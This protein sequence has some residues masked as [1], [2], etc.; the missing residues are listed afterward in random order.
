MNDSTVNLASVSEAETSY[1][2]SPNSPHPSL[3]SDHMG[4]EIISI[5]D[6]S[7]LEN[8]IWELLGGRKLFFWVVRH[9]YINVD[10]RINHTE[11][12]MT[13]SI[14]LE[15]EVRANFQMRDLARDFIQVFLQMLHYEPSKV[16]VLEYL[17]LQS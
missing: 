10:R 16:E 2:S 12:L 17:N 15:D 9:P 6:D 8:N 14:L 1:R 13:L 5:F 4:L 7:Y 3:S 11:V